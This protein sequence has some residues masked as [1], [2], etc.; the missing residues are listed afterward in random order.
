MKRFLI[1]IIAVAAAFAGFAQD[2]PDWTRTG[3]MIRLGGKDA[4]DN[5][6]IQ[7]CNYY[8]A[9]GV[10]DGSGMAKGISI[11]R[12]R[13][14][15]IRNTSIKN[16]SLGIHVKCGANNGASDAD[17]HAPRAVFLSKSHNIT[18]ARSCATS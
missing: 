13:K 4:A 11:D 7:D 3:T 16:V 2:A 5:I 18:T 17:M 15:I 1:S 14:T 8:F 6:E 10:I 12:G 9:G